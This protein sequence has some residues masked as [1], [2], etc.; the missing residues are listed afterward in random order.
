MSQPMGPDPSGKR[1]Y[2]EE[3]EIDR[4]I[5]RHLEHERARHEAMKDQPQRPSLWQRL[6]GK[7]R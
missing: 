5:E 3:R 7:K 6:F 1:E 2:I 4:D